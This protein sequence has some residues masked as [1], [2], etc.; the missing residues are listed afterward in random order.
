MQS[1]EN[2][3]MQKIVE[4]PAIEG[5]I[6]NIT[7][8]GAIGDGKH[9][10]TDAFRKAIESCAFRGGGTV[11][12]PEGDWYTGPIHLKSHVRLHLERGA[13]VRFSTQPRDYLPL[14]FTRWEGVECYNYSALIYAIDCHHVALTGEGTL[15][16]NGSAW[17]GWKQTQK[18]AAEQ[19]YNSE[20]EGI[21]VEDR[22]FGIEHGL[23]PGFIEFVR[24]TNVRIEGIHILNG[25]QWTIHPI[26]CQHVLIRDVHVKTEGP[27]T[28]G[29]NPDSCSDV[30]IEDCVFETGDDCIAINS[31]MNEDGWRTNRPSERILIRNCHMKEGHGGVV[32]GSAMSGGVR[33]V[34]V[35]NCRMTGGERGIRMKSIR[36][37]GGLVENI[38][39]EDIT[40]ENLR[41]E[42]IV[43]DMFYASSTIPPRVTTPPKFMN[44]TIRNVQ[45]DGADIGVALR[46]LPELPLE[47]VTLENIRIR[48]KSGMMVEQV[49]GLTLRGLT[50]L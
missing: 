25:P 31:G 42:A 15:N 27:N 10:N 45:C 23:R 3:W 47:N 16:G 26:Y 50:A 28:D 24:C 18:V 2:E 46:G 38:L 12:V 39:F 14:V 7:E 21:A 22:R 33:D 17:W 32:I 44:I 11:V 43:I 37:R 1:G 49:E 4:P 20:A 30:L 29:L 19:L 34:V 8:F 36:G 6:L 41:N 48:S 35:Q 5:P 9:L 40:M 13:V